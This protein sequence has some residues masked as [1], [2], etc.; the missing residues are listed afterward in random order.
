MP[1]FFI[2]IALLIFLLVG[3]CSYS[4]DDTL[5]QRLNARLP[6]YDSNYKTKKPIPRYGYSE[7]IP[8]YELPVNNNIYNGQLY[9]TY[10]D[11]A[12]NPIYQGEADV[13]NQYSYPVY[14]AEADNPYYGDDANNIFSDRVYPEVYPTYEQDAD[15]PYYPQAYYSDSPQPQQQYQYQ[16]YSP[17]AD[18]PILPSSPSNGMFDSPSFDAP[19]FAY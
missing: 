13:S 9:P 11:E 5:L 4:G 3:G 19:L 1:S 7:D 15:N 14:D 10:E 18:N 16:Y 12:D 17:E 6:Q 8:L 2:S